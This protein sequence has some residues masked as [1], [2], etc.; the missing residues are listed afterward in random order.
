MRLLEWRVASAKWKQ[1]FAGAGQL[2]PLQASGGSMYPLLQNGDLIWFA[3]VNPEHLFL[4]DILVCVQKEEKPV[5]VHRLVEKRMQ[6]GRMCWFTKGDACPGKNT[7]AP[8]HAE[9]ILGKVIYRERKG[10]KLYF[11]RG[12][13]KVVNP[14]M[15][16]L[17][18]RF[19]TLCRWLRVIS[20]NTIRF[21]SGVTRLK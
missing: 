11:D 7:D 14:L 18:Y 17:T 20:G 19:P 15:A 13:F 2:F 3:Y 6:Q 9:D 10:K 5:M 4:G 12:I 16:I 21:L 1:A 8:V